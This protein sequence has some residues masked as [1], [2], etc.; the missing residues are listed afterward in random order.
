MSGRHGKGN[1]GHH[2]KQNTPAPKIEIQSGAEI[3]ETKPETTLHNPLREDRETTSMLKKMFHKP[4]PFIVTVWTLVITFA[5]AVIY[6]FQLLS[7]QD[8]VEQSRKAMRI[9]QRAWLVAT[10]P[11]TFPLNGPNVPADIKLTDIGK[12]VATNVVGHAVGMLMPKGAAPAFDQYRLGHAYIN[13]YTGA[14]YPNAQ[15]P[16]D[17]PFKILEYDEHQM[18]FTTPVVPTP[19]LVGQI[20]E[21]K[22]KFIILFGKIEYCDVFGVKH[23][24]TFCNGSGDAL[25]PEGVRE[26][27]NYNRADTNETPDPTCN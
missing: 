22:E 21:T 23:W 24:T 2:K 17:I 6:Y 16:L 5:I 19:E 9:D 12:T 20:N 26:C 14:I 4:D 11:T 10:V 7:M 25:A 3:A 8:S 15:P 18:R 1:K 13:I 27:I